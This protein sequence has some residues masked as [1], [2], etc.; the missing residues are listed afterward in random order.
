M[1]EEGGGVGELHALEYF[2]IH[3]ILLKEKKASLL[4]LDKLHKLYMIYIYILY[5]YI[6]YIHILYTYHIYVIQIASTKECSESTILCS[7]FCLLSTLWF[8]GTSIVYD[9]Y[10]MFILLL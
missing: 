8:I 9:L 3:F 10:I 1:Q 6:I 2:T 4:N 7:L 5:I